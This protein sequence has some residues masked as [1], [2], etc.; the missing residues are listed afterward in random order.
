MSLHSSRGYL[1]SCRPRVKFVKSKLSLQ[2]CFRMSPYGSKVSSMIQGEPPLLQS[3][4]PMLQGETSTAQ[5]LARVWI[6]GWGGRRKRTNIVAATQVYP[7]LQVH[8][9]P[10]NLIIN[11]KTRL[12]TFFFSLTLKKRFKEMLWG[13]NT[14]K[15][16]LK[17]RV[18]SSDDKNYCH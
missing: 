10:N 1:N 15:H 3:E 13:T 4:P 5:R 9:Y 17:F 12:I 7:A 11:I 8:F 14:Y 2:G 6:M 18:K 16:F